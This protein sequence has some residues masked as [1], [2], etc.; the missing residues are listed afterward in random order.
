MGSRVHRCVILSSLAGL[1][2]YTL[3]H[4]GKR[5]AEIVPAYGVAVLM[6]AWVYHEPMYG[7]Q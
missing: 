3:M 6:Y 1:L 7:C 4:D 5:I 2:R